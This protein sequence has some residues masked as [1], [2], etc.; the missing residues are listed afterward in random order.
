MKVEVRYPTGMVGA[1]GMRL[2]I[3]DVFIPRVK[4]IKIKPEDYNDVKRTML[5]YEIKCKGIELVDDGT[6]IVAT[7]IR[8]ESQ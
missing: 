8:G 7:I 4:E 6:G 3:N 5:G 1:S 2:H